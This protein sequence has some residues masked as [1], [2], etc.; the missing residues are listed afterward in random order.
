[1]LLVFSF[2][3][4]ENARAFNSNTVQ[5][6]TNDTSLVRKGPQAFAKSNTAVIDLCVTDSLKI[7]MPQ[8]EIKPGTL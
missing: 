7:S 3:H 4:S 5:M 6:Q 1:M 8:P 2:I